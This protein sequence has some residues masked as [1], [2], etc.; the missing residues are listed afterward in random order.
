[1][2]GRSPKSKKDFTFLG[3]L[4]HTKPDKKQWYPTLLRWSF[5]SQF[6]KVPLIIYLTESFSDDS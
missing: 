4:S 3:T 2:L 6:F 5:V 1:M